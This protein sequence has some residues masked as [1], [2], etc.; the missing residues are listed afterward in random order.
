MKTA[1][2]GL[3]S[4]GSRLARNLAGGGQAII[5]ADKTFAKAETLAGE[6]G[7]AATPLRFD[8]ALDAADV[9]VLAIPFAA[10]RD[11]VSSNHAALAGKIVVDPSNPIE[12][13]GKGGFQKTIA[14]DQSSGEL[15]SRLLPEGAELVKAFGTLSAE[16][17]R[18]RH[19]QVTRESGAVLCHGLS[20]SRPGCGSPH[21]GQRLRADQR[22]RYLAVDPH[23][24][25]RR[26]PRVR[27]A[28]AVGVGLGSKEANLTLFRPL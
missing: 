1:I 17:P 10:A 22:R 28:R 8:A 4:I 3:G 24:G 27:Q 19:K 9:L 23:R 11:L 20:G 15:L 5:V 7:N 6:L 26:P 25:G 14:A 18:V 2:I 13:D 21:S 12:P 16:L